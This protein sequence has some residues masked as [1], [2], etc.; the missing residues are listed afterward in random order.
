MP[1]SAAETSQSRQIL[2]KISSQVLA[3]RF[4]S[5]PPTN[6]GTMLQSFS[7]RSFPAR[8]VGGVYRKPNGQIVVVKPTIDDKTALAEVRATQIAR[9]VH[10]LVA[11]KQTIKTMIDPT[12]P[13]GQRKFIVIESPYDPR[14]AKMD[15]KFSKS[16]MV[17]Q[18]VA[19]TLR[20]DK[21]LQ[22]PNLS[23]NV[24]AD[25]GTAGVFDRASGFRDFSK[26]MPSME[27]QAVINLL[28]VKGGNSLHKQ[29]QVLLQK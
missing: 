8:G 20:G 29:H 24:L 12:D 11:P 18:L 23:G 15:G 25:V 21:D 17:K 28:G 22:Q 2:D 4:G 16:D 26:A 6:F 3:G 13:T 9:E 1:K 10:G 7:G 19:S 27:Q 14:I 5:V